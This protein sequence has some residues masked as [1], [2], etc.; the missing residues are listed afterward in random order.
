MRKEYASLRRRPFLTPVW[1]LAVLAVLGLWLAAWGLHEASTTLVVVM[2]HA[3]KADDGT[4]DPPLA[5]AGLE[6]AGRLAAMFGAS[7]RGLGIDAI[8]VTQWQ[9]SAATARPLA[10]RLGVP[11]IA[12][13]DD[14]LAGLKARILGEYRGRHVLVIAHA[15]T[16]GRIV[17]ELARGA[18]APPVGAVDYGAAYLIAIPRWSRAT[19][20][21]VALP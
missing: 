20:L 14:D 11:M 5:A 21:A 7:P 9:R 12:L 16:A 8:F 19:V 4:P 3:E 1:I 13:K 17:R 15:D 18:D 6:R 2:R 10:A